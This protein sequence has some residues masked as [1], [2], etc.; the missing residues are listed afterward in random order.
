MPPACHPEDLDEKYDQIKVVFLPQ[1]T[2][3]R[4]Q[5]LQDLGIIQSFKL[6]YY[7][8]FLT[9]VVSKVDECNSASEFASLLM[10]SRR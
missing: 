2:T 5:P 8:R 1:N 10:F 4:P 6:Q 7:N 9:H 3:S